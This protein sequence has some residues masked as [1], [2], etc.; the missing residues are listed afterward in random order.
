MKFDLGIKDSEQIK[1][2]KWFDYSEV[3][4]F[5][6]RYLDPETGR[7]IRTK[8]TKK[9]T[10]RGAPVETVDDVKFGD[11]IIQRRGHN[12]RGGSGKK[13]EDWVV[14][15]S[16][17]PSYKCETCDKYAEEE[18]NFQYDCDKLKA[19]KPDCPVVFL[20]IHNQILLEIYGLLK[21]QLVHDTRLTDVVLKKYEDEIELIGGIGVLLKRMV[22][23]EDKF[24]KYK[25]KGAESGD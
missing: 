13:L 22:F 6:I 11:A 15:K 8:H 24:N 9:S 16:N 7:K 18:E 19:G 5:K 10:R 1:E 2:G 23:L 14:Y 3:V 4:R 17:Y 21:S 20:F 12:N 25:P